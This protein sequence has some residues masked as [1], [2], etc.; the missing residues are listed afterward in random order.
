MRRGFDSGKCGPPPTDLLDDLV[1][2]GVPDKGL[3]VVVP[4]LHPHLDRLDQSRDA[5]ERPA[6][7][8]PVGQ[9]LEPAL[10]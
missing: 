10:D 5:R 8:P 1:R 4:V 2:L 6:A 7:K 9:L 3:G